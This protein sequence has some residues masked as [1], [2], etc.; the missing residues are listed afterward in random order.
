[1]GGGD[2]AVQAAIEMSMISQKVYLLVRSRIRAAKIVAKRMYEKENI[3]VLMEYI[4]I[5]INGE[6]KVTSLV[7]RNKKDEKK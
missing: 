2:S 5:R 3:E 7:V 4:P 6:R 1:M